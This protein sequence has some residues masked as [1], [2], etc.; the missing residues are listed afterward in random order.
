L[1]P[2]PQNGDFSRSLAHFEYLIKFLAASDSDDT[3]LEIAFRAPLNVELVRKLAREM[4]HV[5]RVTT[6]DSR[7]E[8]D[9]VEVLFYGQVSGGRFT[10]LTSDEVECA[11]FTV[12]TQGVTMACGGHELRFINSVLERPEVWREGTVRES[13]KINVGEEQIARA[14]GLVAGK[15]GETETI[16]GKVIPGMSKRGRI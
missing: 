9:I 14:R 8:G 1:K 7:G 10:F 2:E 12:V 16:A 5:T 11:G 15:Y 13:S 6:Q 3:T 4:T